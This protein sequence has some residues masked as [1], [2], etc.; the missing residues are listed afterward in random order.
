MTGVYVGLGSNLD[1]PEQQVTR[2]LAALGVLPG[3]HLL[4]SSSLYR[5]RPMGPPGQPDYVNAVAALQTELAPLAL[6]RA[7]QAIEQRHGRAPR[8]RRRLLSPRDRWGPRVLDLDLLLYGDLREHGDHLQL[9]H[10][11][12]SE[13]DFVL[14]PLLELDP[15]VFIPGKGLNLAAENQL[16]RLHILGATRLM[17]SA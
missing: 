1:C 4:N 3:T 6:L 9:P 15:D 2:A 12:I 14:I 17:T 8:G 5:S 10:P 16:F 11:G 7:L 13:R